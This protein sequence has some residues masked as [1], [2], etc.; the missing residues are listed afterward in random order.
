MLPKISM[1]IKKIKTESLSVM[2]KLM[3]SYIVLILGILFFVLSFLL[4]SQLHTMNTDLENK[5]SWTAEILSEDDEIRKETEAGTFSEALIARLDSLLSDSKGIDYIVIADT[6]STRL[7]HPDKDQIGLQFQGGDESEILQ[8]SSPYITTRKGTTDTQRRAFQAIT[9]QNGK[10]IGFIMVS[11][12]LATI[13]KAEKTII[14]NSLLILGSALLVGILFSFFISKSLRKALLGYEP[15]VLSKMYLQQEQ[16]LDNLSEGILAVN[17]ENVLVYENT[18]AEKLLPSS[19]DELLRQPLAGW[20]HTSITENKKITDEFLETDDA[21][22]IIGI[23]PLFRDKQETGALLVLKDRTAS[24]QMAEQLTG[25]NHVIEALRAN[26]HEFKNELHIISGLLQL[27]ETS[28]ALAMIEDNGSLQNSGSAILN[29][30]ENKTIAA[31]LLGKQN[32]AKELDIDLILQKDSHLPAHNPF[33]HTKEEITIIGNLIEN[34]FEAIGNDASV[35]N[36]NVF[37]SCTEEGITISVDDTGSG[38]TPEQIEKIRAG[39]FTTKGEGHG[40]GLKM[41]QEIVRRKQGYLEIESE[42]GEGTSFTV[43]ITSQAKEAHA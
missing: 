38:M 37:L 2:Q 42:P 39:R 32:R 31:L 10:I 35:R 13:E 30:I 18:A 5:I 8:G 21:S 26:T 20:I 23:Y 43:S 41:I 27:G 15:G 16:I 7:Y 14:F 9:N 33:L 22:L 24:V 4:P 3:I 28:Q 1:K 12:S 11:S 17:M 29:Q 6:N 19:K 25:T 40:N 36:I 34:A